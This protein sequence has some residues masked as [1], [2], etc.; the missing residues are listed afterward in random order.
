MQI[1]KVNYQ[2]IEPLR[3]DYINSLPE[4]QELYLEW[5][6]IDSEYYKLERNGELIGYAAKAPDNILVEFFLVDTEIPH[7]PD[8]F[9]SII[10]DLSIAK[11]YCKS[12]DYLLLN[13]CLMSY[14]RYKLI[15]S[16]FRDLVQKDSYFKNEFEIAIAEERDLPFL[17][18]Q[19][20]GL[21]ETQMEL[22]K[23]IRDRN[24]ILFFKDSYLIGCGFLIKVHEKWDY[25]DIG[26]WVNPDH[27]KQGY[28]TQIISYLKDT[29]LKNGWIPICGCAYENTASQKTLEKNGF[30]SKHK[31]IEFEV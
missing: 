25:Y 13:S 27:R 6:V 21:Y 20:D 22:E 18:E 16:M 12:F 2:E 11:I 5:L 23:C 29:C 4:F 15:G 19:Q 1:I 26:M 31:L 3:I 30:I 7:C 24:I 10:R 17:L 9:K 14:D 28:A 8:Y